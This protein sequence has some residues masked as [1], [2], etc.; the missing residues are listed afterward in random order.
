MKVSGIYHTSIPA[1]DLDRAERFYVD[2]LGLES[3]GDRNPGAGLARLKCGP[4]TVVLFRR[5]KP[6]HRDSHAEDGVYHQAFELEIRVFD[7]AVA[8]LKEAGVF[9]RIIERDS[10]RTIYFWDTEGN[11]EELH[12][13]H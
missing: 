9:D 3:Q 8:K 11:Y 4:D 10:G 1:D 13:S 5:P 2:V 7:E 12:C 6:L